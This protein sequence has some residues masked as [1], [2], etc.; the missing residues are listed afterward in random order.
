LLLPKLI[1]GKF[2]SAL[3]EIADGGGPKAGQ[4]SGWSLFRDDETPTGEKAVAGKCRIYLNAC[5]DDI[6]CCGWLGMN[7]EGHGSQAS[8]ALT[9]HSAM[10]Y[11]L[12]TKK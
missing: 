4:E 6:N 8:E 12:R 2:G 3:D 1:T 10:R 9:G 5:F 11:S 7:I